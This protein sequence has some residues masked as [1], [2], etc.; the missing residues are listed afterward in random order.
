LLAWCDHATPEGGGNAEGLAFLHPLA[1][2]RQ[3][4][5]S[6]QHQARNAL[7]CCYDTIVQQPVGTLEGIVRAQQPQRRPGVFPGEEVA[8][9]RPHRPGTPGLM[10]AWLYGT[11]MRRMECIRVRVQDSDVA[12]RQIVVRNGKGPKDRVVPLPQRP[13][14]ALRQHLATGERFHQTDLQQGYGAVLLP[15]ALARKY[16]QAAREWGWQSVFPSPR[17]A[18]DPRS[19]ATVA[20]MCMKMGC[21]AP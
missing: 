2:A 10:A 8:A 15:Q 19:G 6:P 3:G 14:Q 16:P 13:V 12:Y 5:A 21:N 20:I 9:L 1:V 18:V 17:L 4:A 7:V 11:G